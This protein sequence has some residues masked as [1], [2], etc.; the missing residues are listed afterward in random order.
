[1]DF[2]FTQTKSLNFFGF[3]AFWTF[4]WSPAKNINSKFSTKQHGIFSVQF[5]THNYTNT[6]RNNHTKA[7]K[8]TKWCY[9]L[10]FNSG[11]R[12]YAIASGRIKC[13]QI[14]FQESSSHEPLILVFFSSMDFSI[15]VM[16]FSNHLKC[17]SNLNRI[18]LAKRIPMK[19]AFIGFG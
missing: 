14:N 7:N 3:G 15:R 13:F 2:R 19:N 4:A 8:C 16:V 9:F 17:F 1:M 6:E 12:T 10:Q 18:F 5:S 11:T